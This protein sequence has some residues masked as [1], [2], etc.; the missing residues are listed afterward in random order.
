MRLPRPASLTSI[1]VTS[2]GERTVLGA[3]TG[4]S[5]DHQF[6]TSFLHSLLKRGLKG[7]RQVISDAH[8]G[9]RQAIACARPSA[10]RHG[11]DR[12]R[13]QAVA[14]AGCGVTLKRPRDPNQLGKLVVEMAERR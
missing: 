12:R 7:V 5:E 1:G 9:L 13:N 10:R 6:W 14:S 8:E 4:L 2:T 3:A 11:L